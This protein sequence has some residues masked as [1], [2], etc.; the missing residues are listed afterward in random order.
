MFA[1]LIWRMVPWER[2]LYFLLNYFMPAFKCFVRINRPSVPRPPETKIDLHSLH[3]E[4]TVYSSTL[5]NLHTLHTS[6]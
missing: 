6:Q 1:C 3:T 2:G 5:H 4:F